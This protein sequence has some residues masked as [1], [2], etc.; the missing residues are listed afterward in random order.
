MSVAQTRKHLSLTKKQL[1]LLSLL[2]KFR[3]VTIPLL[4]TYKNL[5]SNSLQRSFNLLLEENYIAK[6]YDA[7]YKIDRKPAVYYL[8][9]KGINA[10]KSDSRFHHAMLHAY[11][12][13]KSVSDAFIQH[14]VDTLEVFNRLVPR[15]DAEYELF[16]CQEVTHF[17]DFPET[18]PDIYLRGEQEYFIMLAY[19]LPPFVIRKRL[20][21]YV[22]HYDEGVWAGEMYP[23]LIFILASDTAA[24]RF[25]LHANDVLESAGIDSHELRISA[26]TLALLGTMPSSS[27]A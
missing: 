8:A 14:T 23:T 4:T 11:Y 25:L 22:T 17:D 13:N 19:D 27:T 15:F 24:R 6:K 20:Q 7:S 3:F 18:K 10:L 21:E 9:S 12:K 26:T 16:T 2:Y 1:H 5:K